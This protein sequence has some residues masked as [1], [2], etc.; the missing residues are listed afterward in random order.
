MKKT[1]IS[2]LLIISVSCMMFVSCNPDVSNNTPSEPQN[3]VTQS[4][5]GLEPGGSI[6]LENI[7]ED[8]EINL[9]DFSLEDGIYIEIVSSKGKAIHPSKEIE[10]DVL[11]QRQDGS[12]IPIPDENGKIK[13]KGKDLGIGNG[14]KIVINKLHNLNTDLSIS[15]E[16]YKNQIE[17]ENKHVAEEYYYVDLKD[18]CDNGLKANEIVI[19]DS[20]HGAHGV[21][22]LQKG[23]LKWDIKGVLNL[24]PYKNSGF[25]IN[26]FL[27]FENGYLEQ[28]MNLHILNPIDVK[29]TSESNY[30][31]LNSD[32]NVIKVSK[33]LSS[34]KI[35]IKFDNSVSPN[36][37]KY[38]AF[39][40]Q[41]N[42]TFPR[43]L[44]GKNRNICIIPEFDLIAKTITYHLGSFDDDFIFNLDW[45]EIGYELG[46]AKI[47]I[48]DDNDWSYSSLNDI[49]DTSSPISINSQ[50]DKIVTWAFK[51]DRLY[52]IQVNNQLL[53][54]ASQDEKESRTFIYYTDNVRGSGVGNL[55]EFLFATDS[56]GDIHDGTLY[57]GY[58]LI[59]N[60][61]QGDKEN[62]IT[63]LTAENMTIT[64]E[65]V[66]WDPE[67]H[68]Y[69][70]TD[71]LCSKTYSEK[72]ITACNDN[73]YNC[74]YIDKEN[75]EFG[76]F[77][78]IY[79]NRY[80]G[81][82]SLKGIP[83]HGTG[84]GAPDGRISEGIILSDGTERWIECRLEEIHLEN[85]I[86]RF[87]YD[88][89]YYDS[90]T[91]PKRITLTQI[92]DWND[93]HPEEVDDSHS[94]IECQKCGSTRLGTKIS[95]S[96]NERDGHYVVLN[97]LPIAILLPDTNEL[98]EFDD[99]YDIELPSLDYAKK[100]YSVDVFVFSTEPGH[101]V[102]IEVDD[103]TN[104]QGVPSQYIITFDE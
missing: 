49:S 30:I 65:H 74:Y 100:P 78:G 19:I 95:L 58:I 42:T 33:Q 5:K 77:S 20:G 75:N 25:A 89:I 63:L 55:R 17:N 73:I 70:C 29:G 24:A 38:I 104:T 82:K 62:A 1:L 91:I 41:A 44:N 10:S 94:L 72:F 28:K 61:D 79:H 6:P 39:N 56:Y 60:T 86:R 45:T 103:K 37:L 80:L 59:D 92:H 71:S 48:A 18:L 98:F 83:A 2:L 101:T 13:I 12:I 50:A 9:S 23:I 14:G 84:T 4:L 8:T 3:T 88:V 32:I 69:K 81:A 87:I 26:M 76:V 46:T 34:K 90:P 53:S 21:R 40:S 11:F 97:N 67:S 93:S 47:Y 36:V 31:V 43:Y 85:N 22:L 68:A 16:E 64:C 35:V 66:K 15:Y 57:T 52:N 51:S 54:D 96:S 102:N 27:N 7:G 99:T